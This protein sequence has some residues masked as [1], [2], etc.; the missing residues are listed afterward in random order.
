MAEQKQGHTKGQYQLDPSEGTPK[1]MTLGG[2]TLAQFPAGKLEHAFVY[3][4][5]KI[6]VR[7]AGPD[8]LCLSRVACPNEDAKFDEA[9]KQREE[10]ISKREQDIKSLEAECQE[11]YLR[12]QSEPEI[13]EELAIQQG[14]QFFF[15]FVCFCC[16]CFCCCCCCCYCCCCCCCCCCRVLLLLFLVVVLFV[17]R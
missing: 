8:K 9:K 16:W 7:E 6:A 4:G 11:I 12:M 3:Q 1:L 14:F 5:S 17:V 2:E 15:C 10:E 13:A